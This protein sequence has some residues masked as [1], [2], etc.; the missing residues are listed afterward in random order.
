MILCAEC[1]PGTLTATDSEPT[2]EKTEESRLLFGRNSS[3]PVI[4]PAFGG[5]AGDK[6]CQR[7][8]EKALQHCDKNKAIDNSSWS[9]SIDLR[10]NT[11]A[12][13]R[14]GNGGRG[15]ETY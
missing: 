11:Q 1:R 10:H 12:Q 14:P 6:F 13:S 8:A 9:S 3:Y 2:S 15:R 4:H 7:S 5:I